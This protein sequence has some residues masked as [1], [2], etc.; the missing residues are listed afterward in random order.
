MCRFSS[1]FGSAFTR[2]M[3]T[4]NG[5]SRPVMTSEW[6][7]APRSHDTSWFNVPTRIFCSSEPSRA[8]PTHTVSSVMPGKGGQ[9]L[10]SL[11]AA[12]N[13]ADWLFKER[14]G[15]PIRHMTFKTVRS[16]TSSMLSR[17]SEYPKDKTQYCNIFCK[18]YYRFPSDDCTRTSIWTNMGL[19]ESTRMSGTTHPTPRPPPSSFGWPVLADLQP[20]WLSWSEEA[21]RSSSL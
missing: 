4:S 8:T 9:R 19:I 13:T 12:A 7:G 3:S 10:M 17:G 1:A 2:S 11:R 20:G 16:R 5:W 18:L 14:W 6:S 21:R 15:G